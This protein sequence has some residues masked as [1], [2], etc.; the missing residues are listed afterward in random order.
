[1]SPPLLIR[2]PAL[3]DES[4]IFMT[5]FNLITYLKAFSPNSTTLTVGVSAHEFGGTQ[6]NS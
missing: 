5:S 4:L 6:L 2:I 3:E 1:M